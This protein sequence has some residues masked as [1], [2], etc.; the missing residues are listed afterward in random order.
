M[1]DRYPDDPCHHRVILNPHSAFY[2]EQ[3]LIDMRVKGADACRRAIL[4]MP[5][6]NVVNGV[7]A[8]AG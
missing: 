3:G 8:H 2:S 7:G 1:A 6:R 4:G 5:L